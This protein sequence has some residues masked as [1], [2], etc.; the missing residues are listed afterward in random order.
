MGEED[1]DTLHGGEDDDLLPGSGADS[2]GE[3]GMMFFRVKL[4]KTACSEAEGMTCCKVV[5]KMTISWVK[6]EMTPSKGMLAMTC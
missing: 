6:V 2:L 4:M 3:A 5:V 1:E